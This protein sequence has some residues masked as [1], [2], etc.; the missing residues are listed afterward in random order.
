MKDKLMYYIDQTDL[1]SFY[2][3][4]FK[5]NEKRKMK[6]R[7]ILLNTELP[8]CRGF[9]CYYLFSDFSKTLKPFYRGLK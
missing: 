8:F 6:I 7:M 4:G 2:D 3:L 1:K 5:K 9:F